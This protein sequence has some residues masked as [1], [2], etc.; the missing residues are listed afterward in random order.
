MT[1]SA[2]LVSRPIN[3]VAWMVLRESKSMSIKCGHDLLSND[4]LKSRRGISGRS[5]AI[6]FLTKY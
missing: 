2:L 3:T 1:L 6:P 5:R 4:G